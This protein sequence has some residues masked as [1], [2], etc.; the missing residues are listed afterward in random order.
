M[1]EYIV[2]VDN[3]DRFTYS[4]TKV[5]S[6]QKNGTNKVIINFCELFDG[7]ILLKNIVWKYILCVKEKKNNQ[8]LSNSIARP[9]FHGQIHISKVGHLPGYIILPRDVF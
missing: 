5:S 4:K 8:H 9:N 7:Q 2:T 1:Y 6:S 3:F